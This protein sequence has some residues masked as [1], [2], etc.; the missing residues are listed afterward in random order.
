MGTTAVLV[1]LVIGIV[2]STVFAISADRARGEA[3]RQAGISRAVSGFLRNDLLGS[4]DPWTGR[5]EGHTVVSFLD[6]AS[7]RLEGKFADESLIEASIRYAFGSTY[8]H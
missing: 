3:E 4:A 5:A 8:L 7:K 6:A 1:V 2:A